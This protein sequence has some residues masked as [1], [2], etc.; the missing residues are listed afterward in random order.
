MD[1]DLLC[2]ILRLRLNELRRAGKPG[3]K[4]ILMSATI[5]PALW[6]EYFRDPLTQLPAPTLDIPGR[7]FP[8]KRHY[9]SDI[10]SLFKT[11]NLPFS[12][13]GWV[14]SEKDVNSYL[15]RELQ[16]IPPEAAARTDDPLK[17][18]SSLIGLVIAHIAVQTRRSRDGHI[19]G[20]SRL[21]RYRL[22]CGS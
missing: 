7:T 4:I 10:V 11:G 17:L 12:R 3:F 8:V 6:I 19:L 21:L 1:V 20:Q 15:Q 18:P 2:F 16:A 9:L 14:F 13:G 5:D 22:G